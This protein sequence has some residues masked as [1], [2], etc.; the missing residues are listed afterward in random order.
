MNIRVLTETE[1]RSCVSLDHDVIRAVGNGFTDLHRGNAFVPPVLAIPVPDKHGEVDVK[2]AYV[3]GLD[4]FAV[5]I[6]SGFYDNYKKGLPNA[7]GMMILISST[8]G[9]PLAV[10]VDNGYLTQVRTGAAGAIA[11]EYLSRKGSLTAGV[12]GAGTQARYQMRALKLVRDFSRLCIYSL[13]REDVQRY[14]RE[15][16]PVLGVEI[17]AASSVQE[18]VE[19]SDIVV[20]CTPSKS[21]YLEAEW[22]RLGTHITAMGSDM[23]DKRELF[24]EV[25]KRA[26]IVACDLR[27]QCFRL[28]ELHHAKAAGVIPDE[29]RVVELGEF[30]SGSKPG[31]LTEEQIT[32]CDLTG[33]GVQDT[34]IAMLTY[35]RATEKNLG[36][37]LTS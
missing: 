15:M 26:H 28:G 4:A 3:K 35:Q 1:I 29:N 5:K 27:S 11:A 8:T 10:L 14:I 19:K 12:I 2:T 23:E 31:R 20:T 9:F 13:Y 21:P 18:V 30:T 32:V 16:Q 24:P 7:C 25:F 37:L 36:L 22:I 17:A 6:A 33:V 34:A